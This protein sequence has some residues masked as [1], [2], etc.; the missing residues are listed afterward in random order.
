M[1]SLR[2]STQRNQLKLKTETYLLRLR[3]I[4]VDPYFV[5]KL[6]EHDVTLDIISGQPMVGATFLFAHR[7]LN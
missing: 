2:H 4:L 7:V 5:L 6:P 3:A 1:H